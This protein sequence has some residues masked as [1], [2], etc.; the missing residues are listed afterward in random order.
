M[1]KTLCLTLVVCVL[2]SRCQAAEP[3]WK[4]VV[5]EL[6]QTEKTGF[7]GLC[8]LVVDHNNG[9]VWINLSDRGMFHSSDQGRSWKRVSEAQPKGR[10]E[11]P[12][13]WLL[14]PTGKTNRM[15]TTLVYGSPLSVSSDLAATWKSMH[16]KSNHMDWCTVDWTDR[17]LRF[18]LTLKHEAGGLLLASHD[19]G[20]SF[21]EVG[22]GYGTGWV[23]D[24]KTA[25]VAQAKSKELP[26][27]QL[28]RTTDGGKTFLS[29]GA[30]SPV[31]INSAQALPK[32]RDEVLYWLVEDGLITT[33]DKGQTWQQ[34]CSLKGAQYGPI[35]GKTAKHMFV[36]T[37]AGPVESTDGGNTWSAPLAPPKDLK[38]IGGLSWLDYDPQHDTLYLMK[39][40]SDLFQLKR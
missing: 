9:D 37:K 40:G 30:F 27:P 10:T 35:F 17:D 13:C 23:F 7:G 5:T 32:W 15:V 22:K 21:I 33:T 34:V 4:P 24:N 25:V 2:H 18:V 6:L 20:E 11:T 38:G 26:K 39:M 31:G 14:D 8:G 36:L 1:L 28:M 16:G 12:G 3:D 29:C 19:G